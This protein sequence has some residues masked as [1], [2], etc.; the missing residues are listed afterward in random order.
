[1]EGEIPS[2]TCRFGL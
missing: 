2:L 1:M